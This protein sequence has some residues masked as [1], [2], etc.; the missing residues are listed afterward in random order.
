M[1]LPAA[2]A[3]APVLVAGSDL[4]QVYPIYG[5]EIEIFSLAIVVLA[6]FLQWCWIGWLL[7]GQMGYWLVSTNRVFSKRKRF[8]NS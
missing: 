5:R 7:E 8:L 1:Y 6:G 2:V 4:N 3:V